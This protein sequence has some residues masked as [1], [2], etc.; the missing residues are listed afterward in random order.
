M[1][2]LF[3]SVLAVSVQAATLDK[4]NPNVGNSY[5]SAGT[6]APV[7]D[8]LKNYKVS[9]TPYQPIKMPTIPTVSFGGYGAEEE[10]EEKLP[11]V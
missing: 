8:F 1:R 6:G 5:S 2:T 7:V 3:A 11:S 9:Y 10:S 4:A